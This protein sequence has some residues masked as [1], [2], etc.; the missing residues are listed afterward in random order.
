MRRFLGVVAAT[1]ALAA[2]ATLLPVLTGAQNHGTSSTPDRQAQTQPQTPPAA[3][4]APATATKPPAEMAPPRNRPFPKDT[5]GRRRARAATRKRSTSSP[6]PGWGASSSSRRATRRRRNACENCHGPGKA[7]VDAGGGKGKGGADHLREER[8]HAGGEA[9]RG[10]PLVPHQGRP[11]LLAGERA[12]V[13]GRG[14]HELPQGHGG[15][16]PAAPARQGDRDRDLRQLPPPE[17]G[18]DDADLA[19]AA[20]RGQDDLHLVPQP[21]RDGDARAPQGALAQ[22]HLLHVPR[23]EARPLPL[24]SPAADREL[25]QLPRPAR[26]QSREHAEDGQAA[27]LPAV[28]RPD[29][30]P[31]RPY[32]R[33]TASLKFVLGQSCLTAT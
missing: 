11:H 25:R 13:A 17:A 26:L 10:V 27:A 16:L 33:D 28:S 7:H 29:S 20:P 30:H 19:H 24:E 8:P 4:P 6:T 9:E 32:G 1:L 12:R 23:R 14:L 15:R 21:A 5:S 18:P 3:P 31:T 22:R 2:A